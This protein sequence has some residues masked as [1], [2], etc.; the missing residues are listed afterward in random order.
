M[1][2]EAAG[3]AAAALAVRE[4]LADSREGVLRS[5]SART[6]AEL[7]D[8]WTDPTHP[9][10]SLAA[11]LLLVCTNGSRDQCCALRGRAALAGC[12]GDTSPPGDDPAS[13]TPIWET[14]H[15]GGHRFAATGVLLP[16]G[17]V[18]GRLDPD[19]VA[20]VAS[21]AAVGLIHPVGLRGRSTLEPV[22]QAAEVAVRATLPPLAAAALTVS[23]PVA[24]MPTGPRTG[25]LLPCIVRRTSRADPIAPSG[26][27]RVDLHQRQLPPAPESCGADADQRDAFEAKVTD[28]AGAVS[29]R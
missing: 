27:W 13:Q 14:S 21:S 11:P 10:W 28:L 1:T 4:P 18:Y 20:A 29:Q 8:L 12:R 2:P 16:W 3:C 22:A 25:P 9:G 6:A 23:E 26:P 17:Y 24:A 19:G 15:L 7:R 5:A